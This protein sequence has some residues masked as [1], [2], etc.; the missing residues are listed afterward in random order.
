MST[1]LTR[2]CPTQLT[3]TVVADVVGDTQE[4]NVLVST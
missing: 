4:V 1:T 2:M 3:T